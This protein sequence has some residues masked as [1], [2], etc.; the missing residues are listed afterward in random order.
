MSTYWKL[1]KWESRDK[2][3][4]MLTQL[5]LAKGITYHYKLTRNK[6][7]VKRQLILTDSIIPLS[8]YIP[9]TAQINRD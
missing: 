8:I 9:L 7:K 4:L 5:I 2:G 3:T 6:E 1:A